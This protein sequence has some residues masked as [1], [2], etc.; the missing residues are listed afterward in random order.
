MDQP[1]PIYGENV[2]KGY[3]LPHAKE[4]LQVVYCGCWIIKP[5]QGTAVLCCPI[6]EPEVLKV[7]ERKPILEKSST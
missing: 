2:G 5:A 4:L 7:L 6:H 1:E 3:I